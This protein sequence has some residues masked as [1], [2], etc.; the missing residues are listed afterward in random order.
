MPDNTI[1]NGHVATK[2]MLEIDVKSQGAFKSRLTFK[3]QNST[4]D[5]SLCITNKLCRF[6][7]H[8][9]IDSLTI[10]QTYAQSH[11]LK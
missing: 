10:Q 7:M 8:S 4:N 9:S 1:Q 2:A 3:R 5:F 11:L 6:K